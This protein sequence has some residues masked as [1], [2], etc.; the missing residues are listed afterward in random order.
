M[1][2]NILLRGGRVVDPSQH[3]DGVA[4]LRLRDGVVS[5]IGFLPPAGDE[6]V[7][8]VAGSLVTPGLVDVHVHLREPGQ[9]W[10]ETIA[11]GTAAAAAGGFTTVFCMPNTEP[12][13][14]SVAALEEFWR[15]AE[16][17]A[18]VRVAPI[19]ASSEG[20]RGEVP[21]DFDALVRMGAVGFSDDGVS[22][23]D[24]GVMLAALTASRWLGKP[25]IEHCE[26]PG[27]SDS[28]MKLL[29]VSDAA[30]DRDVSAVAEEIIIRRDLA[31]AELS[32][33]WL[34]ACHVST[35]QGGEAIEAAK[36]RGVHVTAEVMPHHLVM[37][38]AWVRGSR[39]AAQDLG[40]LAPG[41]DVDDPNTKV[42]PP[43]R[44]ES[45]ARWL[46]AA[47]RRGAIDILATDHAPHAMFE[48][49]GRPFAN[50]A[51]GFTALELA[52]PTLMALVD[53]GRL[54]IADVV[55]RFSTIPARLW[56]LAGGSLRPGRA[57]DI[58]VFDPKEEWTILPDT[59]RSR[60]GNTPLY[61]ARM[62]GRVKLTI[63]GGEVRFRD[64][65]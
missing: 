12:P 34:H 19:A 27:L 61:G 37:T 31:L 7:L 56:G 25:V 18:A 44:T 39:S 35:R 15:R 32:G 29:G 21:V 11:S 13:L 22:T 54:T 14:D 63:V 36:S 33:G 53:A 59:L 10:K 45:D 48:K 17:E 20:R 65:S 64:R 50:A 62:K 4:D 46:T 26:D 51:P 9:E 52:I 16:K 57:A 6:S 55:D 24:S 23:R 49:E 42:H 58:T 2:T 47:L 38:S 40:E 30:F 28:R 1:T 60:S 41:A 43:L 5:E 3:L 8:D